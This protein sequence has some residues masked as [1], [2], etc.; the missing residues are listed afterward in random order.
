MM[1]CDSVRVCIMFYK[2]EDSSYLHEAGDM[3][4]KGSLKSADKKLNNVTKVGNRV[5]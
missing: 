4:A 5:V 1:T 3:T 2:M